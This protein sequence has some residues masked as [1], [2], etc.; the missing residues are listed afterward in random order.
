MVTISEL[1]HTTL[2]SRGNTLAASLLRN[3]VLLGIII[4]LPDELCSY[5]MLVAWHKFDRYERHLLCELLKVSMDKLP[6]VTLDVVM[7]RLL[8]EAANMRYRH[9]ARYKQRRRAISHGDYY[10]P[11]VNY[12]RR[13][14][15]AAMKQHRKR[16]RVRERII[17]Q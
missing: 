8:D 5:T 16:R 7:D 9:T 14:I 3:N 6:F 17:E 11:V 13:I 15:R 10:F 1:V 4:H 2:R 12:Q